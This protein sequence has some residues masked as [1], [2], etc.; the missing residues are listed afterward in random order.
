[1]KKINV[2]IFTSLLILAFFSCKRQGSMKEYIERGFSKPTI[3]D[4]NIVKF[5]SVGNGGKVYVPSEKE[6]EVQFA[7]KNKYSI[8]IT[9]E[10]EVPEGKKELFNK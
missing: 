7:I 6:M 3:E 1:M 2:T 8:Q 5:K 10:L 4:G 9:G